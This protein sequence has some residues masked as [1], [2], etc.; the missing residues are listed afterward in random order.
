MKPIQASDSD[1]Q[2]LIAKVLKR[3]TEVIWE[4]DKNEGDPPEG[5]TLRD[6]QNFTQDV[7]EKDFIQV[8]ALDD[9]FWVT[10]SEEGFN[11]SEPSAQVLNL[12]E[13]LS[14]ALSHDHAREAR[15]LYSYLSDRT[16]S[17]RNQ[18]R[19]KFWR[20]LMQ[21]L[22]KELGDIEEGV[23]QKIFSSTIFTLSQNHEDDGNVTLLLVATANEAEAI[24]NFILQTQGEPTL[25]RAATLHQEWLQWRESEENLQHPLAP[26]VRAWIQETT[27]KRITS[28]YDQKH[29]IGIL[30]YPL[31]NLRDVSFVELGETAHLREFA[32]PNSRQQ[33][34]ST[35]LQ[36]FPP[37]EKTSILPAVMP[38]QIAHPMG[39]KPKTK[40]GAVS[41][42]IR[43]FFEALM[44]LEPNQQQVDM[45]FRLGD[46]IDY[47]Y[48]DG[49]FHRTNQLPYII[50]ALETLHFYATVPWRDDQGD[51]R[52]WRPVHVKSPLEINSKNETP[53]FMRVEMPPDA[54]QGMAVDK[55]IL[56]GLGKAS[57]PQFNAYLT[58]A[59]LWDKYGTHQGKII[60]PTRPVERRNSENV[61]VDENGKPLVNPHGKEITNLYDTHAVKQSAREP[62]PDAI[63]RYPVLSNEDL[64]YACFP[65]TTTQNL[66]VLLKRAQTHWT[67]LEKAGVVRIERLTHGWRILPGASHIE[68]YRGVKETQK[69][70]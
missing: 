31:G 27:A 35:Q 50:N 39:L 1:T 33:V 42:E 57:A 59:Y 15:N 45:M 4:A 34:E 70:G 10:L 49:K 61:L 3:L 53:V 32:T 56:R 7:A 47:L 38:L 55:Q 14:N 62:N 2:T 66:R 29:P 58:A 12:R 46:L 30:K 54:K 52:R 44:A 17:E 43:I 23:S 20:D 18:Q 68:R 21:K 63:K 24:A 60:D 40:A 65:N 67:E 22:K 41:H 6:I 69:R 48:P 8:V 11:T 25:E 16:L 37:A 51:L 19:R 13:R 9:Q 64:I 28:E 5:P 26:I 36:L